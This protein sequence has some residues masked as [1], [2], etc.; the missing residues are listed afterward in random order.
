MLKPRHRNVNSIN[1]QSH[2]NNYRVTKYSITIHVLNNNYKY[3]PD[4]FIPI[5]LFIY[6]LCHHVCTRVFVLGLHVASSWIYTCLR[7]GF[8]CSS[9]FSVWYSTIPRV[10][11]LQFPALKSIS[12]SYHGLP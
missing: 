5:C 1:I 8:I 12:Q 6:A 9:T 4:S 11:V 7:G 3:T 10:S 2:D